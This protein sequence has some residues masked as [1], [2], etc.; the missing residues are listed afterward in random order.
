MT[1]FLARVRYLSIVLSDLEIPELQPI[2][3]D[4]T[5]VFSGVLSFF[6]TYLK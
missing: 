5:P 4:N 2:A 6:I 1:E 3:K